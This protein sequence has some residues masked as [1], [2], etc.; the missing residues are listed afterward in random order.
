MTVHAAPEPLAPATPDAVCG[1]MQAG[2]AVLRLLGLRI[3]SVG[4]GRAFAYACNAQGEL[5]VASG[6]SID[7]LAP[8]H[9]GDMLTA[10]AH[11]LSRSGRTGLYDIHV[12][13]QRGEQ[14]A[15]FRGRSYTM[16]GRPVIG[17]RDVM[18]RGQ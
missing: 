5:T 18:A 9:A 6:F 17:S 12:R 7:L 2:D 11:E 3:D 16:K 14:V 13:N 4:L 8:A 15:A 10:Q 1:A